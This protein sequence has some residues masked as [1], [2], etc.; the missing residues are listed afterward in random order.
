MNDKAS[1][2]DYA[3]SVAKGLIG[4]A[5]VVGP[6]LAEIVGHVIPNQRIDR[7]AK[8]VQ[9]LDD[10]FVELGKATLESRLQDPEIVDLLEDGFMAAARALTDEKR[11]HIASLFK[12]SI[13]KTEIRASQ[14]KTLLQL[15]AELSDP[16]IIL[17]QFYA[18]LASSDRDEYRN[19][20]K[21]IIQGPHAHLGS[22][23]EERDQV[24]LHATMK[25]HLERLELIRPN[26]D[27]PFKGQ[28]PEFD[29]KTGML[30]AKSTDITWLGRLL[31][32]I[33]D[34]DDGMKSK[35]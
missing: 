23:T 16:E 17:L 18:K 5:P 26:Y 1:S 13:L 9:M 27:S 22:S 6:I 28:I 25:T 19:K 11:K 35:Q 24:A 21:D 7:L 12:N 15:L 14:A 20:H 10:K 31:L 4:A 32:R 29:D 33:I 34:L 3:V 8:F 30:K 2:T